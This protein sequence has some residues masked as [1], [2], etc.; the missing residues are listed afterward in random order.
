MTSCMYSKSSSAFCILRFFLLNIA[1]YN[2]SNSDTV[3]K[4][5]TQ[6][7]DM[8]LCWKLHHKT[9]HGNSLQLILMCLDS[10]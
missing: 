7:L 4:E 8:C 2:A 1:L 9:R 6:T 10:M 3:V 5:H